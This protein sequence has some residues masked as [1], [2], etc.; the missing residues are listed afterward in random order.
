[1]RQPCGRSVKPK[2]VTPT[3]WPCPN[4]TLTTG[5]PKRPRVADSAHEN[6]G[7]SGRGQL[8]QNHPPVLWPADPAGEAAGFE[9]VEQRGHPGCGQPAALGYLLA[10]GRAGEV[11][12]LQ[13]HDLDYPH[14]GAGGQGL[15]HLI[16]RPQRRAQRFQLACSRAAQLFPR[17][18]HHRLSAQW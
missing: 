9:P 8:N 5:V 17:R 2:S 18:P 4:P 15:P 3:P 11:L 7:R 13:R 14:L 16:H 12:Q 1:M 6:P 10:G